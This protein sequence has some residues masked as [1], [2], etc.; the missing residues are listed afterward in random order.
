MIGSVRCK[1]SEVYEQ[2]VKIS[3]LISINIEKH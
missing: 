2:C 3:Y 1:D